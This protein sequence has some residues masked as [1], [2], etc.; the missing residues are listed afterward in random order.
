MRAE[1]E[2]SL[3]SISMPAGPAKVRMIGRNAQVA[4]SGASSVSV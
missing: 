3:V 2:M 4:S 1:T